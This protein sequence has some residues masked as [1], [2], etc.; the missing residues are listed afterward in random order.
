MSEMAPSGIEIVADMPICQQDLPLGWYQEEFR[1]Y[2]EEYLALP[3]RLPGTVLPWMDGYVR[4]ALAALGDR[5]MLLAHYYMGGE[6]VKL[7]ER[8]GGHVADSYKLALQAVQH[9]DVTIFV[10]SAVHFMAEAIAIL[11][12]ENQEVWI[13]NPKAGCTLEMMAKDFMVEPIFDELRERYG[14]ELVMVAYMNTSGRVKAM[15]GGSGGAVCTSSNARHV[16]GW[17]LARGKKIFFVPDRN[18]DRARMVLWGSYCGVHTVFR[19][20]HVGY[21]RTRGYRVLVHPECPKPV[22]DAAD[23][24]GSTAYL[25]KAVMDAAPG[26]KLAIAT[27]GHFV[28]NAREQAAL[29]GVEVVNMADIPAPEF[30]AMGCGCATMSRNDPPHLV[31]MLDLLAK[32][33]PPDANRVLPGDAVNEI[34]GVR[35]RMEPAERAVIVRVAR[36]ALER[37]IEITE[38]AR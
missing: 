12:A 30:A 32:G 33:R 5:V 9:P 22:V 17:A 27:E 13:T 11:A 10:E 34:T 23:G 26:T 16:V 37:M 20:E 24:A 7:V 8:Y 36:R 35:R 4:P 15:A 38:G 2:A 1:P 28:R 14:D 29:R 21:W 19:P 6:I 3:D 31:A 18:L 25:W